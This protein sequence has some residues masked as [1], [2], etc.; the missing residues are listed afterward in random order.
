M[1]WEAWGIFI[2]LLA[3]AYELDRRFEKLD[4]IREDDF[5]Y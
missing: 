4:R 5:D 2:L 3:F 1:S